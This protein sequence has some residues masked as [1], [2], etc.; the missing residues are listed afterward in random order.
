[1]G[2]GPLR[3]AIR[4]ITIKSESRFAQKLRSH[5]WIARR[6]VQTFKH[7]MARTTNPD[8]IMHKYDQS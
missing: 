5:F 6:Y 3:M 4:E 8:L 1:M 7:V 2:C